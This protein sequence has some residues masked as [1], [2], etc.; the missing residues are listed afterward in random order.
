MTWLKNRV[1]KLEGALAVGALMG[2][3]SRQIRLLLTEEQWSKV[4]VGSLIHIGSDPPKVY[5]F[6]GKF[7]PVASS[8]QGEEVDIPYWHSWGLQPVDFYVVHFG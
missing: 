4:P 6:L 7:D 2:T 3:K 1:T 8:F 5:R